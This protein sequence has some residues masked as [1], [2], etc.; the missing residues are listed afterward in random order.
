MDYGCGIGKTYR[1]QLARGV[2]KYTGA[3]VSEF[4]ADT[5]RTG[6]FD[7]HLIEPETGGIDVADA[8]FD[9]ACSI[10]VFEHL[11]DPLASARELFRVLKPG[12]TLVATVPNF[13]FHAWRLMALI[14]AQ[15]P[16]EPERPKENRFNGVH[17]RFY[18]VASFRRLWLDAGFVDPKIGSFDDASIW[19][20]TRGFGPLAAVSDFARKHLPAALHLRFLQDVW[21]SVFASRIRV[22]ARKP[23]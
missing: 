6:G 19:D 22:V 21:P 1:V 11:Y 7:A 20:V 12:G 17:I 10:E 18:S 16:S 5:V 4:A 23:A 14:R 9:G 8:T 3:D 2:G 15:V 13:G